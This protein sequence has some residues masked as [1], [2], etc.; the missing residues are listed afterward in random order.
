MKFRNLR[1][2]KKTPGSAN[3]AGETSKKCACEHEN[4]DMPHSKKRGI[5]FLPC[6]TEVQ[7]CITLVASRARSK[8]V[9]LDTMQSILMYKH[10]D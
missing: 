10:A 4:E 9:N 5:L 7:T 1:R 8:H 6:F 2:M 3:A